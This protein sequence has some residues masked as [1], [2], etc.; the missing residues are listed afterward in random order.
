MSCAALAGSSYIH[1]QYEFIFNGYDYLAL[2]EDL[3]SWTAVGKAAEILHQE[4]EKAGYAE[5]WKYFLEGNCLNSLRSQL[6][7]GKEFL[8]RT[9][10]L[11]L[12]M[13]H[14][15]R[16]DGNITLRCWALNFYPTEITLTWQKD[17]SNQNLDMEGIETRPSGDG[18]FQKWA[19]VVVPP[20]E[21]QRYTCHVQHEG[22]PE[23]LTLRWEPPQA[24]VPIMPIVTGL[25]LGAVLMGAVVTFLIWKK[26]N[27]GKK[28]AGQ[29]DVIYRHSSG[30]FPEI[31]L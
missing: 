15:V 10:T 1:G 13:T 9:G 8:L 2:N 30:N 18:T 20:G 17:G 27:K 21:E 29:D 12:H 14:K 3:S 19:A 6:K 4:W 5:Y 31:N 24:S 28:R 25:V 16:A 11:K 26:R 23:P 7:Y 22:L